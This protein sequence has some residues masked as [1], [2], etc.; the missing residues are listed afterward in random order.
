MGNARHINRFSLVVYLVHCPVI[1]DAN[2]PFPVTALEFLAP[3]GRGVAARAS[4]RGTIRAM[5]EAGSRF[6]SFSALAVSATR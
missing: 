5:K 2:P 3:G 1:T 6:N 4:R